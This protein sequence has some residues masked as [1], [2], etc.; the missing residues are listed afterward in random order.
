VIN[1]DKLWFI[2]LLSIVIVLGAFYVTMPNELLKTSKKVN[3]TKTVGK[4]VTTDV[5]ESDMLVALRVEHDEEVV[6]SIEELQSVLTSADASNEEKNTA[7]EE[8]KK[9][10]LAKGKEEEL[11]NKLM[12]EFKVKTFV[13]I[14]NDTISVVINSKEHNVKQANNIMRSIQ[15]EYKEKK[16]ITVKFQ[17]K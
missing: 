9:L 16:Y 10:N 4:E 5:E 13:K 3:T 8:L 11:E 15:E 17:T 2:T 14:E 6:K 1:K 7:F 12:D